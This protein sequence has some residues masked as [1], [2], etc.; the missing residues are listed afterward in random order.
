MREQKSNKTFKTYLQH[1]LFALIFLLPLGGVWYASI[2][3]LSLFWAAGLIA[4]WS[5]LALIGR[6]IYLR[7]VYGFKEKFRHALLTVFLTAFLTT[8]SFGTWV[9]VEQHT[10]WYKVLPAVVFTVIASAWIV[11][12][13]EVWEFVAFLSLFFSLA[14]AW[15]IVVMLAF[16]SSVFAFIAASSTFVV[17]Y[18]WKRLR[19]QK[20]RE[21]LLFA[22]ISTFLLTEVGWTLLLWPINMLS[23]TSIMLTL[24]YL[25][26]T[27][28]HQTRHRKIGHKDLLFTVAP[29]LLFI[30]LVI[31]SAEW[32]SPY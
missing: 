22:L 6:W 10:I 20:G 32:H 4:G 9:F 1:S 11:R 17:A 13:R 28:H 21:A 8:F 24:F 16:P 26:G 27:L 7:Y 2:H 12:R 31:L 3:A 5:T 19:A 15:Q 29:S 23:L 18:F 14:F 25:F 30:T